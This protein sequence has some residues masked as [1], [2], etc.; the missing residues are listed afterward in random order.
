M[1]VI[2]LLARRHRKV[3][4]MNRWMFQT[5]RKMKI[6][7]CI[8]MIERQ[9]KMIQNTISLTS[10]SLNSLP[11]CDVTDSTDDSFSLSTSL[12]EESGSMDVSY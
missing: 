2:Y 4:Y 8:V 11:D 12:S 1:S 6:E 10:S 7:S 3:V 5:K 9:T